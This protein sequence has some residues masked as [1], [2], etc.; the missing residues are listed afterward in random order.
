[1][2]QQKKKS[3]RNI[4][5]IILVILVILVI[6]LFPIPRHYK[7]GGTVEYKSLV[8]SITDYHAIHSAENEYFVGITVEVFGIEVY[9]N[10]RVEKNIDN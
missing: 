7:D 5:L 8:Y 1:M 3:K 2:E 6:L 10:T 9:D 4:I